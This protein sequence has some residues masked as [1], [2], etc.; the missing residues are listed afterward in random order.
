[1]KYIRKEN[2]KAADNNTDRK[3]IKRMYINKFYYA[4]MVN[5]K[6]IDRATDSLLGKDRM[7]STG[8]TVN[9]DF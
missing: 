2:T 1:M 9:C 7:V 8:F 5:H 4:A 6:A 3:N